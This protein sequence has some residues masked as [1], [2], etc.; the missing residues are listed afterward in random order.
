L[1][2]HASSRRHHTVHATAVLVG[3]D[4][5]LLRGP[6]GSGKSRVALALVADAT[7]RGEFAA[8]IGDD[9]VALSPVG[10][11]LVVRPAPVLAGRVEIRGVG[12]LETAH[13]P[14]GVVGLVVDFVSDPPDR[15]PAPED[16]HE[17]VEGVVLPRL[18]LW[19]QDPAAVL[20]VSAALDELVRASRGPT[21]FR[22]PPDKGT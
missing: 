15:V 9:R 21:Q 2:D 3:R 4:A 11:R 6:S 19:R 20:K 22:A 8:M 12:I 13:E 7:A 5:I 18:E 10:N 16:R 17:M 1:P 14:A